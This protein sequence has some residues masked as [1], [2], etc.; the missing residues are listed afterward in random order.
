MISNQA[1][2]VQRPSR[3]DRR[4]CVSGPEDRMQKATDHRM[5]NPALAYAASQLTCTS[6]NQYRAVIKKEGPG[7]KGL[8][9]DDM[10]EF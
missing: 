6:I 5:K 9:R 1:L 8:G 7:V 2:Q 4:W 3:Q 10:L